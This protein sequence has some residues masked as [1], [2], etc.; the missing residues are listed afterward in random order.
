MKLDLFPVEEGDVVV[1]LGA[2][3]GR[4]PLH[5]SEKVGEEGL[6]VAVEP[7]VENYRV[8][9]KNIIEKKA[10]NIVPVLA[11]MGEKT[12]K[13]VMHLANTDAGFG[14]DSLRHSMIFDKKKEDRVVPVL[15]WDDLM[16]L[17]CLDNVDLADVD[18]EGAETQLLE[19]MRGILPD[20]MVV[21]THQELMDE[22]GV[23]E[24]MCTLSLLIEE[25]G[26]EY[27][28]KEKHYVYLR[29]KKA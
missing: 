1:V 16:E 20:E 17:L 8:L 12:S 5:Y 15:S 7:I 22:Y 10:F 18:I 23:E 29:M 27:V 24:Y 4:D 6:V 13:G 9:V 28:K 11:A 26:Y 25:K 21:E 2:W 3:Q 19:G 14:Y